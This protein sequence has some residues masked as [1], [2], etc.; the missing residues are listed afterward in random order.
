V[1]ADA[2]DAVTSGLLIQM[3]LNERDDNLY[4]LTGCGCIT[5]KQ[6]GVDLG[7]NKTKILNPRCDTITG[8]CR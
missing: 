5:F 4:H 2:E 3:P 8:I 7:Y 6:R 1:G